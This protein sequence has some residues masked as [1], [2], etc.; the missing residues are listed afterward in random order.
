MSTDR[1]EKK[2]LLRS[3]SDGSGVQFLIPP[4]LVPGSA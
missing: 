4:N 1:I 3:H 2:V